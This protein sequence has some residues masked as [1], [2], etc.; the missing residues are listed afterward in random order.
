MYYYDRLRW[1]TP[2][3]KL[4]INFKNSLPKTPDDLHNYVVVK[5]EKH[6]KLPEPFRV[7][8]HWKTGEDFDKF[9]DEFKEQ[10]AFLTEDP[11]SE[12]IMH[13]AYIS[14]DKERDDLNIDHRPS[15]ASGSSE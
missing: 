2:V 12:V 3:T 5:L 10:T 11:D 7:V 13:F 9:V 4:V 15:E 14:Q 8:Y 6:E 1:R